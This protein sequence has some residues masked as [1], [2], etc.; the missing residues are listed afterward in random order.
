M[1][2]EEVRASLVKQI[3]LGLV[4]SA[5]CLAQSPG[6]Q[7][8]PE[9]PEVARALQDVMRADG[10][11]RDF[12]Q[13]ARYR[14]DNK[15]VSGAD[16]RV[17]FLGDSITDAWRN[18][19]FGG[20]FP[21]QPYVNRGISG[22]TTS[23]MLLRFRPDVIALHPQAVVILAGTNDIAG[24]TGPMT[25]EEIEANIASLC[26]LAQLHK[27]QVVLASTTPV[28]DYHFRP[29]GRPMTARR[30]PSRIIAINNW[31][32]A[33]AKDNRHVYLDYYTAMLD[34]TGNLREDFSE[35]D[36]HPTA[37]GYAVM[38]PLA[39]DAI[40]RALAQSK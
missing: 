25:N 34:N 16:A 17:V 30:A 35:D 21:G 33:Y 12:A 13:L 29:P 5:T 28:S 10:R 22:Q 37:K 14:E 15:S 8:L 7:Q 3:L 2:D 20:F 18:A 9:C 26:E 27:I 32:R 19:R 31:L 40:G 4:L 39:E 24:N 6:A 38:R 11:L 1:R 23:Q 36:L